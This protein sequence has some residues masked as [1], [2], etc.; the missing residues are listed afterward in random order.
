MTD[1]AATDATDFS[2]F[3]EPLNPYTPWEALNF[4]KRL[5]PSIGVKPSQWVA[6]QNKAAF[7][8]AVNTEKVLL[9][10][11]QEVISS[12]LEAGHAPGE[13][14]TTPAGTAVIPAEGPTVADLTPSGYPK[15]L[16]GRQ[17]VQAVLDECGVT[18]TNSF[19]A[20]NVYR[21]NMATALNDGQMKEL[22]DPDIADEFP[23][24]RYLGIRDG[25]QRKSHEVHFDKYFANDQDFAEVRDYVKGAFDGYACRC[26][27]SPVHKSEWARLQAAGA[28]ITTLSEVKR[29][30]EEWRRMA[31]DA[32]GHEHKGKGEG[33]GQ[34]TKKGSGGSGTK[35]AKAKK[36]GKTEPAKP[37]A[38]AAKVPEQVPSEKAA[39]AKLAHKLV[40]KDIQR[41][42]E[43]YNE[44]RFAKVVQGISHPD[45]EPMDVTTK[46]G[47]PCE[48]KTLVDNSNSKITMDS[49]SQVRKIVKE[50]ETGKTFHTIVSDDQ[51]IYNAKGEGKHGDDSKRKYYYRRGVAGSAR[52]GSLYE[53][54]DE[55]ELLKMMS[56]PEKELPE[57][58]ARTD[59]KLRVGKWKF[60]QDE[61]GK[62]Y[63][64]TKTGQVFRAKK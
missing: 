24:W 11:V 47:D 49:Y 17:A 15:R 2:A 33:G 34:F 12:F 38:K 13:P 26:S 21:T 50:S 43:E 19:Y 60:F 57:A 36:T 23:C 63:Q 6:G 9:E 56:L 42:A 4:F 52:I 28:R 59:G 35:E 58:A 27:I 30:A 10:R 41:Y 37:A 3:A 22:Q 55:A 44:P 32:E 18:P 62:G 29:F 39:R 7:S 25:R 53:C 48:L 31:E 8:L 61:T 20:E 16:S 64:N 46:S 1:F 51:S 54:K 5:I 45:S 40:N 14:A